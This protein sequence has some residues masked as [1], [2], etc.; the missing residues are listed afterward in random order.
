MNSPKLP[1]AQSA[2]PRLTL[3]SGSQARLAVLR[4][5]GIAVAVQPSMVD[6]DAAKADARHRRLAPGAAALM[7]AELKAREV[8][9]QDALVIGGDQILVCD[10]HWFDKPADL[11]AAAAHLRRLRGRTHVLHT[12][13]VVLRRGQIVWQHV[14]TPRLHMRQFSDAFIAA[15]VAAEGEHLLS[16][17]GAYRLEALGI[18]LFDVIEGEHAAILGL[19][20]L[21]LLDFLRHQNVLP[22]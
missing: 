3:A 12:A 8:R 9:D 14:A 21:A 2:T 15:Y 10:E 20:L 7:L 13:L 6:E 22:T 5:A 18:Q 4:A 11:T 16:S 1:L 19:P 17:V